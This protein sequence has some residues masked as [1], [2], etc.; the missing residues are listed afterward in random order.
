MAPALPPAATAIPNPTPTA[1]AA[2]NLPFRFRRIGPLDCRLQIVECRPDSG[3]G[4]MP[5]AAA[6]YQARARAW[7]PVHLHSRE[8]RGMAQLVRSSPVRRATATA[9]SFEWADN[10]VNTF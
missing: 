10:L 8:L 4:R 5:V 2:R 3:G 6:C 1:R 7:Q 9:S